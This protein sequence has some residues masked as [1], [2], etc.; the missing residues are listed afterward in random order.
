MG[1][2]GRKK[3]KHGRRKG[4]AKAARPGGLPE[5]RTNG[6]RKLA[7]ERTV[8]H[9]LTKDLS[10]AETLATM[11]AQSRAAQVVEVADLLA[12][13]YIYDWERL[14]KYWEDETRIEEYLQQ[15]CRISPQRWHHWIQFYDAQRNDAAAAPGPWKWLRPSKNVRA[16]SKDLSQSAELR[17]IFQRAEEIAP[18]HDLVE[19]R[20]IPILTCECVLLA[21][22][23][24]TDS[25]IGHRL[26]SSGINV[27]TLERVA[28]NPRHAPLH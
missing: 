18:S 27:T 7:P 21:M 23:Q 17:A 4:D 8:E 15:I 5:R 28:R 3:E 12:G 10:R 20:L 9:R 6:A 24:R 13:I 16:V 2:F 11:L 26:I 1:I 14:S 19:D 25:E 22:A